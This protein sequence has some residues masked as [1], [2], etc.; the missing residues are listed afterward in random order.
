MLAH[1]SP[2]SN[3]A[4]SLKRSLST[5]VTSQV[6]ARCT[7]CPA[8]VEFWNCSNIPSKVPSSFQLTMVDPL[9]A[10]KFCSTCQRPAN[11]FLEITRVI[12]PPPAG[13]LPS[14]PSSK[15]P[16]SLKLRGNPHCQVAPATNK[17]ATAVIAPVGLSQA[18]VELLPE[19]G[20]DSFRSGV[21]IANQYSGVRI[22][23]HPGLSAAHSIALKHAPSQ[24]RLKTGPEPVNRSPTAL[25]STMDFGT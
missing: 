23:T 3:L 25:S 22:A 5:L 4:M 8:P 21:V 24:Y 9:T 19:A 14:K 10:P 16:G 11:A 2:S 15:P 12:S 20:F 7:R 13:V 17:S 1:V 18:R 6:P